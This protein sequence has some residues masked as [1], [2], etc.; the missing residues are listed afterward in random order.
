MSVGETTR[1]WIPEEMA[2]KGRQGAPAGMLVF[3][4]ELISIKRAPKPPADVAAP[5]ADALE[6][7]SRCFVPRAHQRRR[8]RQAPRLGQSRSSL[9]RLDHRRKIFDSSITRAHPAQFAVNGVIAGWT[10]ALQLMRVGDKW[11]RLDSRRARLPAAS[12]VARPACWSLRSSFSRSRRCLSL[13]RRPADVAAPPKDAKKTEKGVSYKVLEAGKGGKKPTASDKVEVHYTG[14]TT[15]GKMFDSSV[16]RGR[17]GHLPANRCHCW[18]DRW[19][20]GD[21]RG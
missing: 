13:P 5:A 3:D 16:T 14:W 10:D 15:D 7:P 2:Y 18:L 20:A 4:V 8:W 9:H 19:S 11:L 21:E 1:F 6:D 17:T 12:Q